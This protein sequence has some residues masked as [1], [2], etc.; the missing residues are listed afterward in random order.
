MGNSGSLHFSGTVQYSHWRRASLS[1]PAVAT[2][3]RS[4]W[5]MGLGGE[6][7][8]VRYIS[9]ASTMDDSKRGDSGNV[10]PGSPQ[11]IFPQCMVWD[12]SALRAKCVLYNS[13]AGACVGIGL[14]EEGHI[15]KICP[16]FIS[17]Y[18]C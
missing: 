3:V 14:S 17:C 12:R 4:F 13:D 15:Y 7:A 11:Q 10:S 2:H 1:R 6:W 5:K 18:F 16:S 8:F 9:S